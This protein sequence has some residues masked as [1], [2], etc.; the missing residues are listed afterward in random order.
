MT[1]CAYEINGQTVTGYD[2]CGHRSWSFDLAQIIGSG[3]D[4]MEAYEGFLVRLGYVPRVAEEAPKTPGQFYDEGWNAAHDGLPFDSKATR[5]WRDGWNDYQ[6]A[7]PAHKIRLDGDLA[8]AVRECITPEPQRPELTWATPKPV[9]RF[10]G[11]TVERGAVKHDEYN[12]PA[13][14][15]HVLQRM[16]DPSDP[17]HGSAWL[18]A[19]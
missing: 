19:R 8:A 2:S 10:P 7:D 14:T 15:E 1:K 17:A 12:P 11:F 9:D 18:K 13:R 16:T 4:T 6:H 5:A 3:Y